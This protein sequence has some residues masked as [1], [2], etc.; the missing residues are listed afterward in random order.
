MI[1]FYLR[2]NDLKEQRRKQKKSQKL[3]SLDIFPEREIVFDCVAFLFFFRQILI[4][5]NKYA[6]STSREIYEKFSPVK[7]VI[8]KNRFVLKNVENKIRFISNLSKLL[9]EIITFVKQL[10]KKKKKYIYIFSRNLI[11]FNDIIYSNYRRTSF[12]EVRGSL[13]RFFK[14]MV[15]KYNGVCS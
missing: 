6:W 11:R 7:N 3:P 8:S 14:E 10:F 12:Q 4:D 1:N 9:N 2:K 5:A 15:I 13:R